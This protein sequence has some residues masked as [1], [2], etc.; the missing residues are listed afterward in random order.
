MTYQFLTEINSEIESTA[1]KLDKT[2]ASLNEALDL[3]K[4]LESTIKDS[5]N[6]IN[7][8]HQKR[9]KIEGL[10]DVI[11][12]VDTQDVINVIQEILGHNLIPSAP[13]TNSDI[14]YLETTAIQV[15]AKKFQF[16]I[17]GSLNKNGV[18]GSLAGVE[19]WNKDLA[20][21]LTVWKDKG[22]YWVIN[23]HNRLAKAKS[24]G[25]D[26]LPCR[27]IEAT[28]AIEARTIGA[29]MF[30]Q[31]SETITEENKVDPEKSIMDSLAGNTEGTTSLD[32]LTALT[33]MTTPELLSELFQLE[34]DDKIEQPYPMAF[35]AK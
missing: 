15:D 34:L 6:E 20:G 33:G 3:I 8:L 24:L 13:N 22:Q 27:K 12:E 29:L 10:I 11:K 23:G 25:I 21:V 7:N 14:F 30:N 31:P 5:E 32:N 26:R 28:T 18:S 35:K 9:F 16:K 1:K 17:L 4:K 19:V 2:K